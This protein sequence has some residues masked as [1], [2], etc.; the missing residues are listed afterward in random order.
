MKHSRRNLHSRVHHIPTIRFE[1]QELSSF[2]GLILFQAFFQKIGLKE[3]LKNCF[4]H[5]K[6]QPIFGHHVIFLLLIVH[7]LLG[8][9]R[10]RDRDYY[11]CDPLVERMLGLRRIPDVATVS[12]SL[13]AADHQSVARIRELNQSLVLDRLERERLSRVS[14]DYDG[15][16]LSTSR[17]AEGSAVGFNKKKK[18]LRS[19]YPLFCTVAQTGQV[20]DVHHRAGNVHDSHG[21]K[22]FMR[23][24]VQQVRERLPQAVLESRMDSAF[25]GQEF[26]EELDGLGV[27]FTAS[28]PFERLPVLKGIIETR[29]RWRR[30]DES[31]SYFETDWKAKSWQESYRFLFV[32]QKQKKQRKGALQL[33]LFEPCSYEYTY[34]VIVTNK[35]SG[36]KKVL[37]YHNGRGSQE[38]IFAEAKTHGQLDYIPTRRLHGNQLYMFASLMAHNLNRELQMHI[39]PRVRGT[40]EKRKALWNFESLS[41]LRRL[42]CRAG[43]LTQPQGRLTLTLNTQAS[44]KEKLLH[45]LDAVKLAA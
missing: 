2:S 16:V 28:V 26:L 29:K 36:A 34:K 38:G 14:L 33:D 13:S 37:K 3:K 35:T 10:L 15:S 41:T 40:T 32:R 42:L 20:L 24:C 44:V 30:L 25:F 31:W 8:F 4:A 45:Y 5:H 39:K 11:A 1:N 23:A 7:L 18:G 12:R 17:H 19:Y 6:I 9:R 43:R 21:A 22:E 27:E